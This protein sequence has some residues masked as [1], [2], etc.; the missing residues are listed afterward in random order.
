MDRSFDGAR[1]VSSETC[2]VDDTARDNATSEQVESAP[3]TTVFVGETP[4]TDKGARQDS[5]AI[6][7][8]NSA[9]LDPGTEADEIFPVG[10][11]GDDASAV[12]TLVADEADSSSNCPPSEEDRSN[13]TLN[14]EINE[15]GTCPQSET[16]TISV[17]QRTAYMEY[18][19]VLKLRETA[20]FRSWADSAVLQNSEF[21]PL[22]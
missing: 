10:G 19:P 21:S 18:P 1:D 20:V 6:Y 16:T 13:R 12:Q 22:K 17:S 11:V 9:V 14:I 3:S 5:E 8:L 7:D 15:T 2:A 4:D